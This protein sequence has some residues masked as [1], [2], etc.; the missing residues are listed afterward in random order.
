MSDNAERRPAP[1]ARPADPARVHA[2][3]RGRVQGV[4]F[5]EFTRR[6]A[7]A[8][9]LAGWVRNLPDG[10]VELEAEG[11]RA[12][13]DELLRHVHGGPPSARVDAVEITWRAPM[14]ETVPFVVG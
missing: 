6:H 10:R 12:V 3:V 11:P 7:D 9:G 14:G 2:Y 5:R 4:W 13:L 1:G 8:L